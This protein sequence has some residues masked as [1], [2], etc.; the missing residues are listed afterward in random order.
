MLAPLKITFELAEPMV[1]SAYPIHLDALTAYAVTRQRLAQI[2]AD[3]LSDDSIRALANDLPFGKAERDG[4]WVWQASALIPEEV[5]EQAIRMW[6][7]K[8]N[9]QDY[10]NRA[11]DGTLLV[12]A[13]TRNA[14]AAGVRFTGNIDTARGLL[15]NQFDFYPVVSISALSA[16]CIG[17]IDELE[18]LLPPESG[19]LTHIGK[20]ARIGHGRIRSIRIEHA[21]EA[22]DKWRLRVLPWQESPNYLPIQA[23]FRPPYWA[24]ENRGMAFVPSEL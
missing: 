4:E 24:A 23:A 10:A 22:T 16:W 15:K 8:T 13:R 9:T 19:L 5:G 17:D 14:L 3:D 12:G 6:T 7:R 20:R 2:G 1:P 18:A 21:E 11:A